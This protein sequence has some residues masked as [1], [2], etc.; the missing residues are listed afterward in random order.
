MSPSAARTARL[1]LSSFVN[2]ASFGSVKFGWWSSPYESAASPII[3]GGSPRS[4]STLLRVMLDSHPQVWIGPENG[5]VQEAGL[6]FPGMEACLDIPV[7]DLKALRRR[8]SNLGEFIERT[9]ELAPGRAGKPVWGIKSPPIVYSLSTVFH[10]FPRARFVHTVRDGRDVVCSLRTH[11]KYR[12]VDGE[13]VL[14]GIVNPWPDCVAHWTGS[15]AAGLAWRESPRYY[16]VR[17]ED[18]VEEP[19]RVVHDLLRWL[20]LPLDDAVLHY[21]ARSISEGIDSP[22]PGISR[23]VYRSAVNRWQ[24]DLPPDAYAA[25]TP[26]ARQ[27]LADLHY[28]PDPARWLEP[29]R[30]P[31]ASQS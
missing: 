11:P 18:L 26:D 4:G 2:R 7:N 16:E 9:V 20:N 10:F 25:F 15:T 6:N 23:P 8:S 12:I 27:L 21:H 14:T 29:S 1:S 22:H 5:V 24:T 19:E 3:I 30:R 31:Y 13:R 17:Y 28:A